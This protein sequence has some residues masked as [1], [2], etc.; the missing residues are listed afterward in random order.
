MRTMIMGD[1]AGTMCGLYDYGGLCRDCIDPEL[2]MAPILSVL[3]NQRH[4][5]LIMAL[6]L[7]VTLSP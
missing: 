7:S 1:P 4:R 6:I 5:S 2:I 3:C